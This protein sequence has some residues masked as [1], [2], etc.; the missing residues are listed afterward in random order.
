MQETVDARPGRVGPGTILLTS[1]LAVLA[2]FLIAAV[3]APGWLFVALA[4]CA[5]NI[6]RV[7][8]RIAT[9][10]PSAGAIAVIVVNAVLFSVT[11]AWLLSGGA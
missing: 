3:F 4:L 10:G 8:G 11:T 5:V 6:L 9:S 7:I 1:V 2:A